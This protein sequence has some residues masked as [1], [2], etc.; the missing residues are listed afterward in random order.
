MCYLSSYF[1]NSYVYVCKQGGFSENIFRFCEETNTVNITR[2]F[3]LLDHL[4]RN[5]GRIKSH[6]CELQLTN[7]DKH[8][9]TRINNETVYCG[10]W[11]SIS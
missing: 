10:L 11:S 4:T 6:D 3:D 9:I 1:H 5:N 7:H 2:N 8:T